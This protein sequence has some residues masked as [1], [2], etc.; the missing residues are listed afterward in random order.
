MAPE[1]VRVGLIGCGTIGTG[2]VRL[3]Q[4]QGELLGER[5]GFPLELAAIADVELERERGVSLAGYRLTRDWREIVGDPSIQ[6]VIELV[7]GTTVARDVVK[8]ALERGRRVVTAN[9]ALLARHGGEIYRLASDRGGEIAFE[10]SVGGTIPVLRAL[11]EGLCADRIESIFGIVNGTCNFILTE[12]EVQGET[13]AACL[14]RAQ[15]LGI[16]E[17]DPSMDVRGT[18]AAHKLAILL[19]LGLGLE[20][21]PEEIPTRGIEA[22]APLDLDYAAR[23]EL[24]V[25]LLA[26]ARA[27]EGSVEASVQPVMIP[28]GSVLAR[29]DGA[30]NAIHVRGRFSGPTLYYGAGAGS[31]PT[32]SAVVSDVMELARSCRMGA[33][34]RVPPLGTARLGR[35]PLA[36]QEDLEGEYYL[37]FSA[38]DRP[39]VLAEITGAL[40]SAGISIASLLQPERHASQAVPI[41]IVTH[42]AK[43]AAVSRAL[44][45]IVRGGTLRQSPQLLR[46]ERE[47]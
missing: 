33:A 2:V 29:V 28:A 5:L 27:R 24:R 13:Y 20:V 37:R 8:G 21:D 18:D 46:I 7:G 44:A 9:K 10:A 3:F 4:E 45:Q 30:M 41:V 31:L 26:I 11:R 19:G 36:H 32:A 22:I 43:Q 47:F 40:G 39:G 15:D 12:M 38:P 1:G 16:A 25:K 6:V 35:L 14:K 17:A 23:F 34:G 42:R